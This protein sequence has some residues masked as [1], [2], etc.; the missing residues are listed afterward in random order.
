MSVYLD[1]NA[2]TPVRE[3]VLDEMLPWLRSGFGNPSSS[4]YLGRAA[5]EAMEHA[6]SRVADAVGCEPRE[7]IFTSGGTE[8]NNLFIKGLA[9]SLPPSRIS[10]SSIEHPSI[11]KPAR[12]LTRS[13]WSLHA[14]SVD[15][16]GLLDMD[17]AGNA[18]SEGGIASIMFANNECGVVQDIRRIAEMAKSGR[19]WMHTDAVQAFGKIP[20][21][22]KALGVHA[23]SL[24]AHKIYGPK[25][26]GALIVDGRLPMMPIL[27]GGGQESGLRS[28]TENVAAIAGFGA[29]AEIAVSRMAALTEAVASLNGK[30]ASALAA[31]GAV[32]F[33]RNV[34]ALPNTLYFAF[35]GLD[36]GT[37]VTEMD[38]AGFSVA[39]GSACSSGATEPSSTLLAMGVNPDLARGAVRVSLGEGVVDE[40]VSAFIAALKS[41]ISRLSGM[42]R[43]LQA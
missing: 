19:T 12:S 35:E 26:A 20:L 21:D 4:H 17:D 43:R 25:G 18:F 31:M 24:S 40:Q 33:S 28:G 22:F 32:L 36:G 14:I 38:R 3:E 39:S 8:A 42:M 2:T 34:P 9:S 30:L 15:E 11:A 7:V 10:I 16:N 37:L 13:G 29:A 6:R 27:E 1:F 41:T 5:R 23:M